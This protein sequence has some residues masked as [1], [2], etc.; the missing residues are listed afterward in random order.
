MKKIPAPKPWNRGAQAK[1]AI[2]L[3]RGEPDI[4]SVQERDDIEDEQKGD[5]SSAHGAQRC[6][7]DGRTTVGESR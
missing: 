6:T 4:H 7:F 1:I 5:Q 2:H 3:Q